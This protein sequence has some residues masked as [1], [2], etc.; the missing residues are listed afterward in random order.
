MNAYPEKNVR[1]IGQPGKGQGD[2]MHVGFKDARK[3]IIIIYEGDGTSIPEDIYYFYDA[4]RENRAEFI[5]GSRFVYPL[6]RQVMPLTNQIGNIFFAKW[7]SWFLGQNVTDVL[8]GIKA[9]HK[10]SYQVI[11][12]N[13]GFVGVEDPFG[14]FE[15][16]YGAAR[17][18]LKIGEIPMRYRPRPYGESKTKA[19][20]HGLMLLIMSMVGHWVFR[21]MSAQGGK[22][23]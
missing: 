20:R 21:T 13:W 4:M 5:E 16:L 15:L 8:S 10:N 11:Y 6:N 3:E 2:A 19:F 22:K 23:D 1:V 7:F 18:G 17:F 9:I 12:D 14:D